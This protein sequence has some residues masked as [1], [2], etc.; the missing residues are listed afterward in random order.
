MEVVRSALR[1]RVD[2]RAGELPVP[3]VVRRQKYLVFFHRFE[4]DRVSPERGARRETVIEER[5]LARP[6][7]QD[8]V[9]ARV[10]AAP[11]ESVPGRY[12][13]RQL[14]EAIQVAIDGRQPAER[15]V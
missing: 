3:H 14:D 12:L 7:D 13:R 10:H 5:L 11:R 4:R 1:H 2:E 9:E 6:V 15:R 8:A